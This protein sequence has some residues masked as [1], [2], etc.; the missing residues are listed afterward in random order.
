MAAPSP[1]LVSLL[2]NKLDTLI[3][4]KSEYIENLSEP[5]KK[6]VKAL[7]YYQ[8]EHAKLEANFQR[9]ILAVEKRYLELY[10]PLY[11]IRSKIICGESE[12]SK[13]AVEAG[14]KI[15]EEEEREEEEEEERV[16]EV[17]AEETT[18]ETKEK[19]TEGKEI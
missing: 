11:E 5:V 17:I 13:E 8:Q 4:K 14:T 1:H 16:K 15:D 7:K 19:G 9:E 2:Q 18:N 3:G 6:R 12:P 10:K